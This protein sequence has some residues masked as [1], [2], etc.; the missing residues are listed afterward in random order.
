[1]SDYSNSCHTTW[2]CKYHIVFIPKY[3][4]KILYG[5][6]RSEL[7]T[8]FHRL[9]YQKECRIEEGYLVKDH[10]HMLLSI[11]PKHSVSTIVG[12]LKGNFVSQNFWA[13]GYFVSTVGFNEDAVR[14]YIQHQEKED[15][16]L[17][18]LNFFK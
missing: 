8:V 6:I 5:Q 3:R 16:R 12:F 15:Q 14:K 7:K 1:M 2:D 18:Q 17:S 4:R 11:P 9:A 13:R 10:V